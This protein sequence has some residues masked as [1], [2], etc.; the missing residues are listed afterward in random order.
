MVDTA[1]HCHARII[2]QSK[3]SFAAVLVQKV[4]ATLFRDRSPYLKESHLNAV[5][6]SMVDFPAR[7][8]AKPHS[9]PRGNDV[10]RDL[11]GLWL[12]RGAS[13]LGWRA[14]TTAK[15]FSTA[16]YHKG[17][18]LDEDSLLAETLFCAICK[19][20]S[21]SLVMPLQNEPTVLLLECSECK[22][23]QAS[24]LPTEA[25][26]AAY[27]D[28]YYQDG[29]Q[30]PRV[31]T[32]SPRRLGRRIAS[33]LD[34]SGAQRNLEVLDFGGGDGTIAIAALSSGR[35][36]GKVVVVDHQDRLATGSNGIIM[37]RSNSLQELDSTFDV[38]LASAVLE[39][40]TDP[41]S[42][43]ETLFA[44]LRPGGLFYARTPWI[45]PYMKI[46]KRFGLKLDFT[47]PGYIFDLG[48]P[49]WDSLTSWH[50][51]AASLSVIGSRPS[52]VETSLREHPLRT[53]A[54]A[55]AKMPH[56]LLRHRWVWSGGWEWA[57]TA[58]K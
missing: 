24:R 37:D 31:T 56:S 48:R 58:P 57:A 6:S 41:L 21:L 17:E 10:A 25:S 44:R 22:A 8:Y 50:S 40:L 39:H 2:C 51:S 33:Y 30:T 13:R 19:S 14:M 11:T 1:E 15:H 5:E 52:P 18:H 36:S 35:R 7:H 42:A 20:S 27:Y 28:L 54:A 12:S 32:G 53:V 9:Q 29:D 47:F 55:T 23:C 3:P 46:A 38:I 49:F 16:A 45:V 26:L 4:Q 34:A 43:L